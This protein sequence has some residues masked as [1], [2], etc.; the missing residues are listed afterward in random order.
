METTRTKKS[1]GTTA[2]KSYIKKS[3]II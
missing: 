3:S 2:R 1:G